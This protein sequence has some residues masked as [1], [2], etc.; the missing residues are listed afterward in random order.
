MNKNSFYESH[1]DQGLRVEEYF[2]TWEI[3]AHFHKAVE[4]QYILKNNYTINLQNDDLTVKKDEILLVSSR[5]AHSEPVQDSVKSVMLLIPYDFF[6]YFP[7]FQNTSVPYFVLN[8]K[9]FNKNTV[10]PVLRLLVK[11][12][13]LASSSNQPFSDPLVIGWTNIVFG[14]LFSH[15][16]LSFVDKGKI[17]PNFFEQVL[18][19][20]DLHYM[21]QDLSLKKVAKIFGYSPSYL[22]RYF[23]KGF[24][25]NFNQHIR[26]VR[27]KKFISLYPLQNGSNI[28]DLALQCGFSSLAAFYRAFHDETNLSPKQYFRQTT[29]PTEQQK[30]SER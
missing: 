4:F 24:S 7:S 22:S 14:E 13:E 30:K 9:T 18:E 2:H 3:P 20:I 10:L 16:K 11:H 25:I 29:P 21:E 17:A 15:Y 8:D 27:I 5:T 19:F 12:F 1:T 23:K 28:L 6:T 26:S